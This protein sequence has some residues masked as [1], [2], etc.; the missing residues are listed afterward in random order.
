MNL[1]EILEKRREIIDEQNEIID[2]LA[3]K[4]LEREQINEELLRK[5]QSNARKQNEV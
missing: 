4:V 3:L 5:M 1:V 2:A